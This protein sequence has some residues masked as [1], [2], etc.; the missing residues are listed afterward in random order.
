MTIAAMA[1]IVCEYLNGKKWLIPNTRKKMISAMMS[2]DMRI[3]LG[4]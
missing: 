1:R 2:M 3:G 4:E